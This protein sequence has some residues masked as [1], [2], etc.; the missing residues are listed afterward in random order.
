MILSTDAQQY[1]SV[2]P[3]ILNGDGRCQREDLAR[4]SRD[5]HRTTAGAGSPSLTAGLLSPIERPRL[6]RTR[7]IHDPLDQDGRGL[8]RAVRCPSPERLHRPAR[9]RLRGHSE[10]GHRAGLEFRRAGRPDRGR[11]P[12]RRGTGPPGEAPAL[13][14]KL[15]PRIVARRPRGAQRRGAGPLECGMG[16]SRILHGRGDPGQ[17]GLS[18]ARAP[19]ERDLLGGA[20]GRG[21]IWFDSL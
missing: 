17:S 19:A 5:P 6:P 18:D 10:P 7:L 14:G 2:T 11:L 4:E 21:R 16:S 20:S 1:G 13:C 3:D 9:R 8:C 15:R 12:G